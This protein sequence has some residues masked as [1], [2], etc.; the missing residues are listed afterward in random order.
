M[1][2]TSTFKD[3]SLASKFYKIEQFLKKPLV[4]RSISFLKIIYDLI[5]G[6]LQMVFI[7]IKTLFKLIDIILIGIVAILFLS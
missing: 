4:K 3:D 5:R 7:V 2:I 6:L 1:K